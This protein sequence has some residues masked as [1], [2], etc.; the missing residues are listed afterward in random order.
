[1]ALTRKFLLAM[2][3]EPEKVDEIVNAN[4]ESLEGVIADR[5]KYKEEASNYKAK[6][7]MLDEVQKELD[8]LKKTKGNYVS[9]ERSNELKEKN[10][11]LQAEFD[12]YKEDVAAGET[13]RAKES[14]YRG[15]LRKANIS[16]KRI[17]KIIKISDIDSIELDKDGKIKD[18]EKI[19]KSIEEEWG[20]FIVKT[21]QQGA[22]VSTP[23]SKDL[24]VPKGESRAAK[25]AA[26]Y[27]ANLYG[28]SK[29]GR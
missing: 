9:G 8:D 28:E 13:K 25:I 5:D 19:S 16:D 11:A 2:G 7:L 4:A 14:A 10:E 24:T 6:S 27:H 15:L 12:K 29:E 1:M 18:E 23:P 26:K 20:D 17:D 3:I 22:D 21:N